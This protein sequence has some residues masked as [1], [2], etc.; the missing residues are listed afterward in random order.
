MRK[1]GFTLIELIVV[2]AVLGVLALM[3]VPVFNGYVDRS[4]QARV[5]ANARILYNQAVA[6]FSAENED[7]VSVLADASDKRDVVFLSMSEA[8][9]NY[10]RVV[11]QGKSGIMPSNVFGL[12]EED[13]ISQS[14]L[15]HEVLVKKFE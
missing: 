1:D 12:S 8:R 11:Y 14:E 2:M 5:E 6:E 9:V 13:L 15:D 4:K 10:V 3:L 7:L